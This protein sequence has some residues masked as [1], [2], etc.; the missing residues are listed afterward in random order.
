MKKNLKQFNKQACLP[1][2]KKIYAMSPRP[3]PQTHEMY[4]NALKWI[5][6]IKLHFVLETLITS[7]CKTYFHIHCYSSHSSHK[8]L[9]L[10]TLLKPL[11]LSYKYPGLISGSLMNSGYKNNPVVM[12]PGLRT[13]L[14]FIKIIYNNITKIHKANNNKMEG[15]K[16]MSWWR[17]SMKTESIS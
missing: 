17:L 14:K 3:C 2:N 11:I 8:P 15:Q 10:E 1:V 16:Q 9:H 4:W 6:F 5:W 13:V 7:K 12:H